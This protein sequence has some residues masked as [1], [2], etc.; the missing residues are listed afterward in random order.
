MFSEVETAALEM[1]IS[2]TEVMVA[3]ETEKCYLRYMRN[4]MTKELET[5]TTPVALIMPRG[6][7]IRVV[8]NLQG[9]V[10]TS[11]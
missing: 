5:K 3:W 9:T 2:V 4:L 10:T 6:Q 8:Q 1:Q 7:E 11:F